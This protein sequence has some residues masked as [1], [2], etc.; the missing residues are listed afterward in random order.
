MTNREKIERLRQEVDID[1]AFGI[2]GLL[3]LAD[4]IDDLIERVNALERRTND[5]HPVVI[6]D[7]VA[8]VNALEN[9]S[10][11]HR[12]DG[13]ADVLAALADLRG[14]IVKLTKTAK[15]RRS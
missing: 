9:G 1:Y 7:V 8:R 10:D 15:K 6:H 14:Q 2:T 3:T 13:S 5:A 12:V 4:A 11:N